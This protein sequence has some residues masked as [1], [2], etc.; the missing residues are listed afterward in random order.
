VARSFGI[1]AFRI[2]RRDEVEGA[3]ATLLGSEGPMLA[4]VCIDPKSN[5]WPLVPP[6]QTNDVMMEERFA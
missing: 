1:P 4:H 6:G 3:I 2:T 5:V